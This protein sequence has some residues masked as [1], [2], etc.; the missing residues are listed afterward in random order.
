LRAG[1]VGAIRCVRR[2]PD[3][4]SEVTTSGSSRDLSARSMAAMTRRSARD[5]MGA[6]KTRAASPPHDGQAARGP[7]LPMGASTSNTPSS[8]QPNSYVTMRGRPFRCFSR[9]GLLPHDAQTSLWSPEPILSRTHRDIP[10]RGWAVSHPALHREG[11]GE[12]LTRGPHQGANGRGGAKRGQSISR[13]V[14]HGHPQCRS[15]AATHPAWIAI[16]RLPSESSGSLRVRPGGEP[17]VAFGQ[18]RDVAGCRC[19]GRSRSRRWYGRATVIGMWWRDSLGVGRQRW[20]RFNRV[21][22]F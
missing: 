2:R 10:V 16:R 1:L 15:V 13:L 19:R 17:I 18:T 20:I 8:W 9:G 7:A 11:Q 4:G 5:S 22:L 14:E 3:N 6:L 21:R 12:V